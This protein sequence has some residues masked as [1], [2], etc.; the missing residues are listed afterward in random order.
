MCLPNGLRSLDRALISKASSYSVQALLG[1]DR[2]FPCPPTP[3]TPS[4]PVM[5]AAQALPPT[6]YSLVSFQTQVGNTHPDILKTG[7]KPQHRELGIPSIWSP[8]GGEQVV[9]MWVKTLCLVAS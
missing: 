4:N 2:L 3:V 9:A 5:F 8:E 1:C 7:W 6:F